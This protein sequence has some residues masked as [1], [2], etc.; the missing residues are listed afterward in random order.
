M[1]DTLYLLDSSVVVALG[2]EGHDKY[3]LANE[4]LA[5]QERFAVCPIAQGALARTVI[6]LGGD[7]GSVVAILEALAQ[8][9]GYSF[10]PDSM[11][12][13]SVGGAG[14]R[15]HRQVTDAYLTALARAGGAK[16]ATFD[17]ALAAA[18]PDVAELIG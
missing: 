18:H 5:S 6:R 14:I 4:W 16:L 11:P 7:W 17:A 2:V 13:Q 1:T 12:C 10:W 8:T 3:Q 15:G 9:E